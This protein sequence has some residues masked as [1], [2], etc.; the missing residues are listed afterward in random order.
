MHKNHISKRRNLRLMYAIA[1]LQ[2]MV[3]YAPVASLYR[4]ATGLTLGQIALIEG[5]SFLF[6]L[7]ME[8][9]WGMLADRIGY[10]RTMIL[11][12]GLYALSK[13]VFWRAYSFLAFLLERFI[14]SAAL[15]GLSGV[16]ESIVYLSCEEN[17]AQRCFGR[18][19]ALSAAG[20]ILSAGVCALFMSE[21]HRLAALA[22]L[23]AYIVA[24]LISPGVSEVRPG[25]RRQLCRP[26]DFPGL[27]GRVLRDR[28][29]ILLLI[30]LSLLREGVQMASVWLNQNQYLRCGMEPPVMGVARI[31][32]AVAALSGTFS[33]RAS[34]RLGP[35]RTALCLTLICAGSCALMTLTRSPALS[36]L[37]VMLLSA[38]RA[39]LEPLAALILNRQVQ[40]EDRATALSA[41]AAVGHCA[42]AGADALI[43]RTADLSLNAALILCAIACLAGGAGFF[44]FR[45]RMS[46]A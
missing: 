30:G 42:S 3:F 45:R 19:N 46:G 1:L 44:L 5:I 40:G 25:T 33:Q 26:C 6:A 4:Q 28:R 22:T 15:A 35:L 16:D 21:N 20:T 31:L 23:V 27:L 32:T 39:L 29:L 12:C 34:R 43:G 2:G 13:L 38:G 9:P 24:L 36:V 11:G 41:F 37:C 18:M 8:L 7:A 14:L 17:E 10:R